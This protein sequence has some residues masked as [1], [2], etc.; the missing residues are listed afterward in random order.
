MYSFQ[1]TDKLQYLIS[2]TATVL[3]QACDTYS[4]CSFTH[5]DTNL[6][7]SFCQQQLGTQ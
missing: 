1:L 3:M 4:I 6:S 7:F 2:Y 5:E